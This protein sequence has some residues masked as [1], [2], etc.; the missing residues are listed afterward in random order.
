MNQIESL[1]SVGCELFLRSLINSNVPVYL[2]N[3]LDNDKCFDKS[4]AGQFLSGQIKLVSSKLFFEKSLAIEKWTCGGRLL[5]LFFYVNEVGY[6]IDL[7]V[8]P[9]LNGYE[10]IVP[11]Q[12]KKIPVTAPKKSLSA[13]G[14]FSYKSENSVIEIPIVVP[15][16]LDVL[17]AFDRGLHGEQ[18]SLRNNLFKQDGYSFSG[19][20]CNYLCR[21][22]SSQK[23]SVRPLEIVFLD[24]DFIAI[25]DGS[26]RVLVQEN[27]EYN[28]LIEFA[29]SPIIK[30][31]VKFGC[32]VEKVFKNQNKNCFVCAIS[33]CQEEDRRFLVDGLS[34]FL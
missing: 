8:R 6:F 22:E 15:E 16:G 26:E 5:R 12:I 34:R 19:N 24:K 25:G 7:S 11:N 32:L 27:Q 33:S 20:V 3:S 18:E 9:V 29:L 28:V 30:R 2:S 17:T 10:S 14:V 4:L 23:G 13:G 21:D 31:K 1:S